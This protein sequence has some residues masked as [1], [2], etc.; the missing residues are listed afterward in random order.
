MLLG[1][2]LGETVDATVHYTSPIPPARIESIAFP[3]DPALD[4]LGLTGT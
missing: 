2:A 4:R 3:G 1:K